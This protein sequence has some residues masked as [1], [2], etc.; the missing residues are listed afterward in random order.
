MHCHDDTLI[1]GG[2]GRKL[3]A[4][5]MHRYRINWNERVARRRA[6]ADRLAAEVAA[7]SEPL[8]ITSVP[9]FTFPE[10]PSRDGLIPFVESLPELRRAA[11][12][13][14]RD[15]WNSGV[16]L[17][18]VEASYGVIEVLETALLRLARYYPHR[19]FDVD[20]PREYFSE[21]IASRFQW[22]NYRNSTSGTGF[23]GTIVPTMTSGDV[24][25]DVD[26]V[27]ALL[28]MCDESFDYE[29]WRQ[30]WQEPVA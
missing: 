8:A 6:E 28:P 27:F 25:G 4:A 16:T 12:A 19:H 18:M 26:M 15:G 13:A 11:Y 9:R 22:H 5:Q 20:D 14:A 3:D 1:R 29:A 2:F 23:S 10:V 21:L 30:R 7:R 17:R 24:L